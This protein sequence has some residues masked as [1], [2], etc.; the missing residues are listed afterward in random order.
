MEYMSSSYMHERIIGLASDIQ[1]GSL[2]VV[3]TGFGELFEAGIGVQ[4]LLGM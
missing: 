1:D 3:D 2:L 4:T